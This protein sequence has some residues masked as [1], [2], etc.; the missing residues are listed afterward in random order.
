MMYTSFCQ[1]LKRLAFDPAAY[2]PFNNGTSE[3]SNTP[4][5][6][7]AYSGGLDSTVLL[8]LSAQFA[9]AHQ[10]DIT[11]IHIN[12]GLSDNA[13][14]WQQHCARVCKNLKVRFIGQSVQV[15]TGGQGL[16][17]QARV[18]R[19]DGL[20][21]V[22]ERMTIDGKGGKD[23]SKAVRLLL[24]GQHQQDQVETFFLQLKRGA[25]SKGLAAMAAKS[26]FRAQR[27]DNT[28]LLRPL[29]DCSR[30]QLQAYAEQHQLSWIEDESNLDTRFDRNFLRQDVMPLFKQRWQHFDA[31]VCRSVQHI[32]EQQQ[33]IEQI[34][35]QDLSE[36]KRHDGSL[37]V[38]GLLN[39]TVLRRNNV[40][41]YWFAKFDVSMP[42]MKLMGR[43][44]DEVL[45]ARMDA[46]PQIAWL[47]T[48]LRRFN[49]GLYLTAKKVDCAGQELIYAGD[50]QFTQPIE[51]FDTDGEHLG[52]L[53]FDINT[54]LKPNQSLL[55]APHDDEQ[56]T[57]G[58]AQ[59]GQYK[60]IKCQ[61]A[62]HKM[63]QT[64]GDLFKFYKVAPWQRNRTPLI[65]YDQQLVAVAGLF[66]CDGAAAN[67]GL[68]LEVKVVIDN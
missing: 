33:L 55:R 62:G 56:V 64:L 60:Q 63:T 9:T 40:L 19:Y 24:T 42:S 61:R 67:R 25:G 46:M 20:A 13:S 65:Y 32:S 54:D 57:I 6:F 11:A 3:P 26:V 16:E 49:G 22:I 51:L 53:C 4:T 68:R 31:M 28:Y 12:H 23:G 47:Q 58:F 52:Q 59:K 21:S 18:A 43:I 15:Q 30:A 38:E 48:V 7:I 34:S 45:T 8:H 50:R 1:Q 10:L 29:L 66:V 5:L 36:L 41:R 39:L 37:S 35:A 17:G 44:S 14:S 27:L 2:T